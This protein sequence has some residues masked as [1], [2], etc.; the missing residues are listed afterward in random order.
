MSALT[1]DDYAS[2]VLAFASTE[3]FTPTA[4]YDPDGDCIEFL[5][6]ADNFR[7]V[8]VDDLITVYHSE[9]TNEI[10]GSLL[11]G[12]KSLCSRLLSRLP[13]FKIEIRGGRVKLVHIFQA[14]LWVSEA[15]A[16]GLEMIT[17]QKLIEVAQQTG[18][19]VELTRAA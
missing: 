19:E 11:K 12:V 13:G 18:V 6:A 7:A 1:N 16:N 9:E 2:K 15:S 17:Y 5:A 4:Y 14:N 10:I 3:P 8:R